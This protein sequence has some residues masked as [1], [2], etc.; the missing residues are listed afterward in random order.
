MVGHLCGGMES[1]AAVF[2]TRLVLNVPNIFIIASLT[3]FGL[4]GHLAHCSVHLVELMQF[5]PI[6]S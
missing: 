2:E 6:Q 3:S 5:L 1:L 4:L